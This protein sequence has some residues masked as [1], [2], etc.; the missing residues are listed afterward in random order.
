[1]FSCSAALFTSGTTVL[2]GIAETSQD[3]L[4]VT[5]MEGYRI[6]L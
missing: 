2:D 4:H 1:M 3:E 5:I 6:V